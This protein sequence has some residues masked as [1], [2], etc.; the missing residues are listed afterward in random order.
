MPFLFF[1]KVPRRLQSASVEVAQWKSRCTPAL[2]LLPTPCRPGPKRSLRYPAAFRRPAG[3]LR[4]GCRPFPADRARARLLVVRGVVLTTEE[5]GRSAAGRRLG[6][7]PARR[8][9]DAVER[10]RQ[11]HQHV[12]AD[13]D[14]PLSVPDA[15]DDA[16]RMG[17]V[18]SVAG[19]D[20]IE[21]A[22]RLRTMRHQGAAGDRIRRKCARSSRPA[23]R[24]PTTPARRPPCCCRSA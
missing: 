4:A 2:T 21:H 14:L 5:E 17:R 7:R 13:A 20:G 1:R 18:Q 9:A 12:L 15:G 22:G 24:R 3:A 10:R 16:R 23:R 8:A 11:L 19:A 6:R